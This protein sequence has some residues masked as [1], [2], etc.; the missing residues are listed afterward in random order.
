LVSLKAIKAA[1]FPRRYRGYY[2]K[3]P[4][5]QTFLGSAVFYV[6]L[7]GFILLFQWAAPSEESNVLVTQDFWSLPIRFGPAL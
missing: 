4:S 7:L 6:G 1:Y 3:R 5:K 2:S